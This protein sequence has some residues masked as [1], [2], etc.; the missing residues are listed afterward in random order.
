MTEI[1]VTNE[2]TQYI[3]CQLCMDEVLAIIK[4]TGQS[5]SPG[6]Y[7]RLEVGFT[8]IG[9]QVRCRRHSKNICHIDFQGH[10]H[11]ANLAAEGGTIDNPPIR[12]LD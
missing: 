7:Q 8:P 12:G 4:R 11:P 2:I 1:H 5:Q 3:H 6:T 10:K 9:L